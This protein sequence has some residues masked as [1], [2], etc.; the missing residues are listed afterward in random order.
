M[1]RER[2]ILQVECR[3]CLLLQLIVRE[4]KNAFCFTLRLA[5]TSIPQVQT[6]LIQMKTDKEI[7]DFTF[8]W[9]NALVN[10]Q[11]CVPV[12]TCNDEKMHLNYHFELLE[13]S[14]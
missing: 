5:F 14:R 2:K 11:K 6:L 8:S 13:E 12:V 4:S 10:S 1:E 3:K 7:N 9:F